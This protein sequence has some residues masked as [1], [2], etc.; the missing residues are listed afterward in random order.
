MK[1]LALMSAAA[2]ALLVNGTANAAVQ[3]RAQFRVGGLVLVW[4]A[5][6]AG[7]G[8]A[9][10]VVSDFY[11]L[12]TTSGAAGQDLIAGDVTANSAV[13]TGDLSPV[14]VGVSGAV[15]ESGILDVDDTLTAFQLDNTTN[16]VGATG[17]VIG[18]GQFF[19]A[20]NAAFDIRASH[21]V[22]INTFDLTDPADPDSNRIITASDI[23]YSLSID[24]GTGTVDPNV[25][26]SLAWGGRTPAD[27]SD[28]G[29]VTIGAGATDTLAD[30][31]A[32]ATAPN[33]VFD[34]A[35]RTASAP[36]TITQQSVRFATEYT[37]DKAYDLSM[38]EGE[39]VADIT[40]T[41]FTP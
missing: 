22:S 1:K 40:Y 20:S 41:I 11:L 16:I 17:Q 39:F 12:P 7:A 34:G 28:V 9:Q 27:S 23:G 35:G 29:S 31:A 18:R 2:L 33:T 3:D 30:I 38:G 4:G 37:L 15:G 32:D 8:A 36:G 19:V 26:T 5:D 6:G 24:S 13:V 14:G 10:N 21:N 25:A